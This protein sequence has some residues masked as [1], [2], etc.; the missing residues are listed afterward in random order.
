MWPPAPATVATQRTTEGQCRPGAGSGERHGHW[1]QYARSNPSI[2]VD[3][4]TRWRLAAFSPSWPLGAEH[5]RMRSL[6]GPSPDATAGTSTDVGGSR[7]MRVGRRCSSVKERSASR[8]GSRLPSDRDKR[9]Q[10]KHRADGGYADAAA[11]HRLEAVFTGFIGTPLTTAVV[12]HV[13]LRHRRHPCGH[14]ACLSHGKTHPRGDGGR[15]E[16]CDEFPKRPVF[17]HNG[18]DYAEIH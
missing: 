12:R 16:Q 6:S 2:V 14:A 11:G 4:G 17:R 8:K 9:R 10:W 18:K 7:W 13:H 1:T 3:G 15:E 5:A